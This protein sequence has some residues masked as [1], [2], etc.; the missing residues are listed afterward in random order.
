MN[1]PATRQERR[2]NRLGALIKWGFALLVLLVIIIAVAACGAPDCP[3]G[4]AAVQDDGETVCVQLDNDGSDDD[5][6]GEFEG[7]DED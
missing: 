2:K 7:D 6:G 5:D 4:T 3:D 1:I